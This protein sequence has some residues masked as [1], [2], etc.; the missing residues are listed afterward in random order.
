MCLSDFLCVYLIFSVSI[1]V[2]ISLSVTP[3]RPLCSSLSQYLSVSVLLFALSLSR[4]YVGTKDL[5]EEFLAEL[6]LSLEGLAVSLQ[7]QP[8]LRPLLQTAVWAMHR[9]WK[10]TALVLSGDILLLL[11]LLH[12]RLVL[13]LLQLRLLPLHYL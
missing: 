9:Q 1:S 6:R 8:H 13:G 3:S 5:L 7:Q 10:Q 11:L 2:S 4:T 12:Q